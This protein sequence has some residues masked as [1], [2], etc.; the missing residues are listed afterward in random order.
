M[1]RREACGNDYLSFDV[2]AAGRSHTFDSFGCAIHKLSPAC[3]RCGCT[4]VGHGVEANS[5]RNLGGST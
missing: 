2:L 4:I 1:A 5:P 3:A